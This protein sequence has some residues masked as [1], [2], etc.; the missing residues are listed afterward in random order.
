M[1]RITY[2]P[3]NDYYQR[4]GIT[5]TATQVEI[6]RAY[7]QLAKKLHPD[8]SGQETTE[9]FQLLNEAYKVLNDPGL[10]RQYD[11]MR[12]TARQG[13]LPGQAFSGEEWWNVPHPAQPGYTGIKSKPPPRRPAPS[14]RH[15]GAWLEDYGIGF[16]RPAYSTVVELVESPYRYVLSLL[17]FALFGTMI[18]ILMSI[19]GEDATF[20]DSA[21]PTVTLDRLPTQPLV[22]GAIPTATL[23]TELAIQD[24]PEMVRL[25]VQSIDFL[26]N[27]L[28]IKI[29][30]EAPLRVQAR[31]VRFVRVDVTPFGAR[32]LQEFPSAELNL[33][34]NRASQPSLLPVEAPQLDAG[35][36]LLSWTPLLPDGTNMPTCDQ[37]L[38]L[39]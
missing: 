1:K 22:S 2:H 7:R 18:F 8:S 38:I 14:R 10:R 16:L 26:T 32:L 25:N 34:V 21:S 4:L 15:R 27:E 33:L 5:P 28:I 20:N 3:H 6:Q 30:A 11:A 17:A 37:L 9:A 29:T 31:E 24:C 23:E 12:A 35:T 13:T 39:K 19:A 36:Y